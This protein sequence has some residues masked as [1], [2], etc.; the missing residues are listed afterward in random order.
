MEKYFIKTKRKIK[1]ITLD[2][3]I[4]VNLKDLKLN[5]NIRFKF[6]GKTFSNNQDLIY[7]RLIPIY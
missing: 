5:K 2:G 4:I 7:S 3:F 6:E 1:V